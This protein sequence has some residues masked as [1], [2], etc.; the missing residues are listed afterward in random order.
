MSYDIKHIK[1]RAIQDDVIVCN[2]DFGEMKTSSGIVLRSDDGQLHGIK[3]RWGRVYR[4]GPK[5]TE[6]KEG[7]WILIEHGRWTRKVKIH[8]GETE[9]EI[10]KVDKEAILAVSDET[11]SEADILVGSSGI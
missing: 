7:Q 4:V 9:L 5:Q 2:M 6:I 1:I 11:P 8:D 3:P 10:Q